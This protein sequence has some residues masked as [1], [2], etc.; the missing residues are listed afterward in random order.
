LTTDTVPADGKRR[1]RPRRRES[2]GAIDAEIIHPSKGIQTRRIK[3]ISA[4]F[5][6]PDAARKLL[7]NPTGIQLL[8]LIPGPRSDRPGVVFGALDVAA[9][10]MRHRKN[11]VEVISS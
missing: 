7:G 4:D 8:D 2:I 3:F 9:I 5:P 6:Y 10:G 11:L 1:R